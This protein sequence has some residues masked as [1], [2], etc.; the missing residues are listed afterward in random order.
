M[1]P[2]RTPPQ[3][4][5]LT[6]MWSSLGTRP[7]SVLTPAL[8]RR[9]RE[10]PLH[11]WFVSWVMLEGGATF[12]HCWVGKARRPPPLPGLCDPEA[13]AVPHSR[14]S[15]RLRLVSA[16]AGLRACGWQKQEDRGLPV[17]PQPSEQLL[18]PR[19]TLCSEPLSGQ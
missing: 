15:W 8:P 3:R 14:P 18:L 10:G 4:R 7:R 16:A 11:G 13:Q 2:R 12:P 5:G 6:F 9:A 19:A 17:D 1:E